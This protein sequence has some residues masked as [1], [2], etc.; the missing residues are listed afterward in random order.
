MMSLRTAVL[1]KFGLKPEVLSHDLRI[2]KQ[3]AAAVCRPDVRDL[4][5]EEGDVLSDGDSGPGSPHET[6]RDVRDADGD[7]AQSN[8]SWSS[9]DDTSAEASGT[10]TEEQD[11]ELFLEA[12]SSFR[13]KSDEFGSAG[14]LQEWFAGV[15]RL[16]DSWPMARLSLTIDG[17]QV[18]QVEKVA[19]TAAMEILASHVSPEECLP[20]LTQ[21]AKDITVALALHLAD[22]VAGF[23]TGVL[24]KQ[25]VLLFNESTSVLLQA[26]YWVRPIYEELLYA[27]SH[28]YHH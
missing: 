20:D 4:L 10:D 25:A 19:M 21:L 22:L 9:S 23:L 11:Q 28:A 26:S 15:E 8:G 18:F 5:P 1:D 14:A 27:S 7:T 2:S 3:T 12:Y 13:A 24:D 17:L 6:P 16:P